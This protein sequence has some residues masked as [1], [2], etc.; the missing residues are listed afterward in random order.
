MDRVQKTTILLEHIQD[1][2]LVAEKLD[3]HVKCQSHMRSDDESHKNNIIGSFISLSAHKLE[4]V[5]IENCNFNHSVQA[6]NHQT[7]LLRPHIQGGSIFAGD[8]SPMGGSGYLTWSF[9]VSNEGERSFELAS[10]EC[11]WLLSDRLC[12]WAKQHRSSQAISLRLLHDPLP[13]PLGGR[14][15]LRYGEFRESGA[16]I[17]ASVAQLRLRELEVSERLLPYWPICIQPKISIVVEEA[18][19]NARVTRSRILHREHRNPN[20][21][22]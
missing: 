20:E 13:I 5:R 16:T 17:T 4:N 1:F 14:Y 21:P 9:I 11:E 2:S 15:V 10:A 19:G 12:S 7:A 22:L 8:T 6:D 3:E 18:G